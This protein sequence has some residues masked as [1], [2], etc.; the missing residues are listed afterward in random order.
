MND[1][2]SSPENGTLLDTQ[3]KNHPVHFSDTSYAQQLIDNLSRRNRNLAFS[4]F[5]LLLISVGL[6]VATALFYQQ[7]AFTSQAW[8][9]RG[10]TNRLQQT[11][12]NDLQHRLSLSSQILKQQQSKNT[13]QANIAKKMTYTVNKN[14]QLK[15][16]NQLLSSKL[17]KLQAQNKVLQDQITNTHEELTQTVKS[18]KNYSDTLSQLS[19]KLKRIKQAQALLKNQNSALKQEVFNRKSAFDALAKRNQDYQNQIQ[20]LEQKTMVY[21]Q[22]FQDVNSKYMSAK[23]QLDASGSELTSLRK[24]YKSLQ[25]SLHQLVGGE[26]NNNPGSPA[27][28]INNLQ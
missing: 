15:K 21:K 12:I 8:K 3:R 24:D 5:A 2:V 27:P 1:T 10:Q 13:S 16:T 14:E 9:S 22:K 28:D 17:E 25:K 6:A 4:G 23:E 19:K 20:I 26:Q 18:Q 7:Q 11:T